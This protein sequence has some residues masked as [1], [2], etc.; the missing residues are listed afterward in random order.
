MTDPELIAAA[1]D[2]RRSAYAP[3]S[4]FAVGAALVLADGRV[5]SGVNVENASYGLTVCA[6]RNAVAAA[7]S[8][9]MKPGELLRIAI[10]AEAPDVV[11]PC[12]ACRQVLA[13]FAAPDAGVLLH[14]VRGKATAAVAFWDLLPRAFRS[15]SLKRK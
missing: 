7:V 1:V 4:K 8:A 5:Y 10:A 2:A 9:G 11:A 3:Y 14:N 13:E 6:E 15:G 12:G